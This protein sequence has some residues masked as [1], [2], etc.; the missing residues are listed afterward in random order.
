MPRHFFRAAAAVLL[1]GFARGQVVS[2][3]A[4]SLSQVADDDFL[5]ATCLVDANPGIDTLYR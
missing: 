2:I 4:S 3:D 1:L 5:N